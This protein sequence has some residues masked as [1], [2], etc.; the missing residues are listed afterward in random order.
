MAK[1]RSMTV[2]NSRADSNETPIALR[3]P[4]VVPPDDEEPPEDA[5]CRRRTRRT[6]LRVEREAAGL[7]AVVERERVDDA[8]ERDDVER[9]REAAGF[10][11]V[12][13]DAVFAAGFAAVERADGPGRGRLGR[14]RAGAG[15]RARAVALRD[16]AGLRAAGFR[17]AGLRAAGLRAV[18]ARRR[19]GPPRVA[20]DLERGD[21]LGE[22]LDLGA[23]ALDLGDDAVLEHLADPVRGDRDVAGQLLGRAGRAGEGPLDRAADGLDRLDGAGA[24]LRVAFLSAFFLSFLSFFA[25]A[26]RS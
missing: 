19:L 16:A 24:G 6:L 22:A 14:G 4:S 8:V 18:A 21:A 12:E 10:L 26:E 7:R 20:A 5:R 2:L 13:D 15:R 17:A 1:T 9:E 25:M 3:S 23:E 11:A